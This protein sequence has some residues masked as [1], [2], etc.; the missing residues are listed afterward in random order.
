MNQIL[1]E[2]RFLIKELQK[3]NLDEKYIEFLEM[4]IYKKVCQLKKK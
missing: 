3:E 4:E 2:I 1:E